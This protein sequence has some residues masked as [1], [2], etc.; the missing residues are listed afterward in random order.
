[1][2]TTASPADAAP[3]PAESPQASVTGP[4]LR[5]FMRSWTTGVAVVT[6]A[7]AGRPVG[8]TVNAFTSVSLR[9]PL[10]LVSLSDTSRTLAA[11]TAGG[12]FAV[13][14]LDRRQCR[15]AEH[16]AT[17]VADRFADLEHR[18]WGGTPV[19]DGALGVV[20]CTVTQ[21]LKVADHGL[22]LGAPIRC[23]VRADADPAV[24]FGG[25]YRSVG[26]LDL[27]EDPGGVAQ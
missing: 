22:V 4:M 2:T 19:L 3:V 21:V 26:P 17:A 9:P 20:L 5:D 13:N 23:E 16:F 8:C 14:L 6:S 10:V 27:T 7:L 1:M 15:L 24:F 12:R 25:R 11:I 18:T